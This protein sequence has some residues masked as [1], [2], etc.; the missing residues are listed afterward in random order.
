[1]AGVVDLVAGA[2]LVVDAF[3]TVAVFLVEVDFAVAGLV[4]EAFAREVFVAVEDLAFAGVAFVASDFAE[5]A[6]V[7][8]LVVVDTA[9]FGADALDWAGFLVAV[10]DFLVVLVVFLAGADAWFLLEQDMRI[11]KGED[12]SQLLT[13]LLSDVFFGASFTFPDGPIDVEI[14]RLCV[15]LTLAAYPWEV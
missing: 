15:S 9:F 5:F 4:T 8:A 13:S 14:N 2:F 3:F 10:E 1:L 11:K 7:L 12:Q 6:L